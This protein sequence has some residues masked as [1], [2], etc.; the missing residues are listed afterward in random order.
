MKQELT[1]LRDLPSVSILMLNYNGQ[2][3]LEE[4]FKSV[5][6]LNYPKDKYEVV[7]MDNASSDGSP[8]W[9]EQ[10]YPQ[11]KL[12]RLDKNYGFAVGNNIGVNY[13]NGE[14]IALLNNDTAL[15]ENWLSELVEAVIREPD[16]VYGSKVLWYSSKKHIVFLR[17]R[18]TWWGSIGLDVYKRDIETEQPVF[19]LH[20]SGCGVLLS[21]ESYLKLG[22]F[23]KTYFCCAEDH[24]LGWKAWLSGRKVYVI[25]K[26]VIYHKMGSSLSHN[27]SLHVYLGVRNSLRN[28]VKFLEMPSLL[29][30]IPLNLAYNLGCYLIAYCIRSK[31]PTLIF[32]ILKAYLT[33]ISEI[34]SLVRARRNFQKQRR[35]KEH[36]LR[37]FGLM[38]GFKESVGEILSAFRRKNEFL[39]GVRV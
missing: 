34:P 7:V 13:C 33:V 8:D 24:E 37:K 15:D 38:L 4:F 9:I 27:S 6:S 18:F 16:A 39:K 2:A 1:T 31:K 3:H 35:F 29:K 30:V 23:D 22:G 26:A 20:A 12:V 19:S 5:F 28:F 11:V 36:D 25:P 14:F 10:N 32:P 17:S 21:K